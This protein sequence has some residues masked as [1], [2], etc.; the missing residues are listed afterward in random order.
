MT[1]ISIF[2]PGGFIP[3][4]ERF[5]LM[6]E[7][8]KWVIKNALAW[9]GDH[10]IK[11]PREISTCALNLSGAS[12]SDER[13]LS[14]IKQYINEY[15]VPPELICFE[16]TETVA[17][18]NLTKATAFIKKFKDIGCQFAL[19]DFGSGLSSFAYLKKLPVNYLKID[20]SFITDLKDDPIDYAMVESI[21]NIG[22]LMGLKTIAEYVETTEIE[23]LVRKIGIDFAQG[24]AIGKPMPMD[25]YLTNDRLENKINNG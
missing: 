24:Y 8:D 2:R 9:F 17:I 19:D 20:G 1:I 4:A 14:K 22:Q 10:C 7:I 15:R 11:Y 5:D 13:H 16:I 21:N 3:A 23:K 25:I 18:A 6:G 12:L